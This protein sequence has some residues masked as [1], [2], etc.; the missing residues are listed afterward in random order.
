MHKIRFRLRF[1][2]RPCWETGS[3]SIKLTIRNSQ[4][5]NSNR[6]INGHCALHLIHASVALVALAPAHDELHPI[7]ILSQLS[8]TVIPLAL[9]SA[10]DTL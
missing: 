2:P 5:M 7:R 10:T 6:S 1:R 8:S 9:I 4:A 3:F